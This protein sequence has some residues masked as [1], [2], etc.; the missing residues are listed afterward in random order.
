MAVFVN[1]SWQKLNSTAA[2]GTCMRRT[3]RTQLAK[4]AALLRPLLDELVFVGGDITSLLVTDEG[5]GPARTTL[6]VD[7]IAEI[8]SY[9]EY[10]RFGERLRAL[11]FAE[12]INEGAPLCRWVQRTTILDVMPLDEK[13]LGFSNRWYSAAM[14]TAAR[15]AIANDLEMRVVTAPYFLAT[16]MEAFHGRG[17]R[18]FLGSHDIEDLIYVVDGRQEIIDEA[19]RATKGLRD[20]L[21]SQFSR[22]LATPEFIDSL[23]GHLFPDQASQLRLPAV[24]SRL[25]DLASL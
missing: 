4:I 20:Y 13:V 24:I 9:A 25:K 23:P 10:A 15:Y 17:R 6:D 5:A 14:E 18:D 22:L 8:T 11:G 2:C 7:A 3:D 21:S 19:R 1:G 12:D 16:K